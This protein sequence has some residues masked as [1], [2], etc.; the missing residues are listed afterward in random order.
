MS[1]QK[2]VKAHHLAVSYGF[3]KY[4]PTIADGTSKDDE[5]E[6]FHGYCKRVHSLPLMFPTRGILPLFTVDTIEAWEA[7]EEAE[8]AKKVLGVVLGLVKSGLLDAKKFGLKSPSSTP[9]PAAKDREPPV[10]DASLAKR[11]RSGGSQGLSAAED[12]DWHART[13]QRFDE[14]PDLPEHLKPEVVGGESCPVPV[15][16]VIEWVCDDA[17]LKVFEDSS[18]HVDVKSALSKIKTRL[19]GMLQKMWP[20]DV[21]ASPVTRGT[22]RPRGA[23]HAPAS[24]LQ[25]QLAPH[26]Q[27]HAKGC[28]PTTRCT[29][30]KAARDDWL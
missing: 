30:S 14:L 8:R 20:N 24:V 4:M 12:V 5:L 27:G 23:H 19:D 28:S 9:S 2:S 16:A 17:T 21:V 15:A 10:T 7:L 13:Q 6:E 26:H 11:T 25:Q 3:K 22:L 29:R 18:F 1:F